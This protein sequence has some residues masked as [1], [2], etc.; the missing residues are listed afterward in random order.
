M[1]VS[2]KYYGKS[3]FHTTI[4]FTVGYGKNIGTSIE[5]LSGKRGEAPFRKLSDFW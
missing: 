2:R 1:N 5:G 4:N 3:F